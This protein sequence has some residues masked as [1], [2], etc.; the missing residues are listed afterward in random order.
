M[1]I[2]L[3]ILA[4]WVLCAATHTFPRLP[5]PW[6]TALACWLSVDLTWRL[7]ASPPLASS[8]GPATTLSLANR[9]LTT[10]PYVLYALPLQNIP[11]LGLP[12]LPPSPALH[13]TGSAL[14]IAGT[15][16]AISARR[17]LAKS[18][19]GG[20]ALTPAHTL[21]L[22]G[23]YALV[24]HPIYLGL[25]LLQSGMILALGE[26]RALVLVYGIH[27]LLQKLPLEEAALRN[28]YPAEYALY[29]RQVR[30]LIPF[31]W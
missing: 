22:H 24:R 11:I 3:V 18:W 16:I 20:V 27:L 2:W 21:I 23:P 13:W 15:I 12:F 4:G 25:L 28:Q 29:S 6:L 10:L 9:L 26:L 7:S 5:L 31:V 17:T 8:R 1:T 30:K 14:C 19:T